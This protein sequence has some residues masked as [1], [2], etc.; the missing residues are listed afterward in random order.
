MKFILLVLAALVA[1]PMFAQEATPN[2]LTT[3]P[4][5]TISQC[6]TD[7]DAYQTSGDP[8]TDSKSA[9]THDDL[10]EMVTEMSR[11]AVVVDPQNRDKYNKVTERIQT[12]ISGRYYNFIRRHPTLWEQFEKEDAAG[13]R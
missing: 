6:R 11:C 5:P 1:A 8:I 13:G 12:C 9:L 2:P 3:K 10:L 4:T 7:V